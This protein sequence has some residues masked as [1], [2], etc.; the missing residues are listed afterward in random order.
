MK[1]R[2]LSGPE[3]SLIRQFKSTYVRGY[4]TGLFPSGKCA[5]E[6]CETAYKTEYKV[7]FHVYVSVRI[8]CGPAISDYLIHLK[9]FVCCEQI[10]TK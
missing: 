4:E 5:W 9:C 2:V 7:E 8:S 6:R 1:S 3:Q 10:H